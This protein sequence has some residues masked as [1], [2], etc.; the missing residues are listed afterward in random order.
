VLALT[1]EDESAIREAFGSLGNEIEWEL[2]RALSGVSSPTARSKAASRLRAKFVLDTFREAHW[3]LVLNAGKSRL[4]V[5]HG[6]AA[7]GL[8]R[9]TWKNHELPDRRT[10]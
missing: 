5:T 1:G 4:C 6:R 7:A 10:F 9:P 3:T 2:S 8:M